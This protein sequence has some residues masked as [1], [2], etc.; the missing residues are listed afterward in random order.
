MQFGCKVTTLIP[1]SKLKW[2]IIDS[3]K[4]MPK[5]ENDKEK[6]TTM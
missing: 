4:F 5:A 6:M 2:Q 1:F 3:T